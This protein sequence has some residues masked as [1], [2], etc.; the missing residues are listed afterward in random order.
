MPT[1]K[2][3]I[4]Y[5]FDFEVIGVVSSAS[6]YKLAWEINNELKIDLSK[7]K[8]IVLDF[9]K[10]EVI[11]TNFLFEEEHSFIRLIKN[12]SLEDTTVAN[13]TSL[14]DVGV[15]EYFLP[16]LKKYDYVIQLEGSINNLY[17]DEII[18][19]LNALN[20]IQLVTPIDLDDL[21]EKDNLIFE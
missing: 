1:L 2:L 19:K 17:S 12:K 16:E 7:G 5:D 9:T 3:D 6:A 15:N 4:E 14:F 20:K 10:K 11:I 13:P 21:K 8:D 18:N